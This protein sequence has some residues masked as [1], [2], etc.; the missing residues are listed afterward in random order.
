MTILSFRN[1]QNSAIGCIF[2][3]MLLFISLSFPYANASIPVAY[4]IDRAME[5][6]DSLPLDNLEGIWVYPEDNVS[7]LILR[8]QTPADFVSQR[9]DISVVESSDCDINPGDIIGT[10]TSTAD[11]KRFILELFTQRKGLNLVKPRQCTATLDSE[12]SVMKLTYSSSNFKFRFNLNPSVLLPSLWRSLFRVSS[13]SAGSQDKS[14]RGMVR[15]Y[16][17]YDGNGSSS[18][19]VRY[20]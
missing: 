5:I 13:S 16:P 18:R 15:I 6:C 19:C 4:D 10:M 7:V 20:L 14:I 1:M 9:Y 2:P 17:S 11:A 3:C 12:G 8:T